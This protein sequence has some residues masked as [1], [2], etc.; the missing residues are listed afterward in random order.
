M[1]V[2]MRRC[3]YAASD[4]RRKKRHFFERASNFSMRELKCRKTQVAEEYC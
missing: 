2:Q 3:L 1:L 4:L